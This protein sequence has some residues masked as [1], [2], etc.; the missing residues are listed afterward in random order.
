LD[1]TSALRP[2]SFRYLA[3]IVVPGAIGVG[4]YVFVAAEFLEAL[5]P[6]WNEHS[7]A[8]A[9][10]VGV[11]V[12][13]LG[14]ILEDIGSRIEAGIIDPALRH[15]FPSLSLTWERYLQLQIGDEYIG[16]RYLRGVVLR[17]KFELSLAPA[18]L[19]CGMGLMWL[20]ALR[21]DMSGAHVGA[22]ASFLF[23]MAFGAVTEAESSARILARTRELLVDAADKAAAVSQ[24]ARSAALPGEATT[25][26]GA[27]GA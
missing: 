24:R 15:E 12:I 27:T 20:A 22:L 7:F 23:L 25:Q 16:Q 13:A 8:F 21:T 14:F 10:V 19:V 26:A 11:A 3:L 2:D 17:M 9:G 5:R 1:P 6:F 4:P 18:L